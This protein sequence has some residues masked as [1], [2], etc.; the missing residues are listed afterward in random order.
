METLIFSTILSIG[1]NNNAK[2][3]DSKVNKNLIGVF[4]LGYHYQS[5]NR[6]YTVFANASLLASADSGSSVLVIISSG[7]TI[8]R[9]ISA[10]S[11]LLQSHLQETFAVSILIC[12]LTENVEIKVQY[13]F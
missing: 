2:C 11:K 4:C 8:T 3:Q 10:F 6:E 9:V 7:V 5:N 12:G 1:H 13:V